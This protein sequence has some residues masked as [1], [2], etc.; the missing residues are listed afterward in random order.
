MAVRRFERKIVAAIAAV[1]FMPLIGALVLG[2]RALRE[3][4]AVGVNEQVASELEHGLSL[5]QVHFAAL[6]QAAERTADAVAADY[7]L[8]QALHP[9]HSNALEPTTVA[10]ALDK[11]LKRY[12]NV[13]RIEVLEGG[14]RRAAR[15]QPLSSVQELRLLELVRPLT[16][17]GGL[18]ARVTVGTS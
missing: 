6:R 13:V 17:G 2:Q 8:N 9:A 3:A 1:A 11:L 7:E 15:E 12:D 18:T 5:Y 14:R 4:Y 10:R 16:V